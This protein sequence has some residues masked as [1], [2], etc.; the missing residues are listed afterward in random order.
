MKGI[1][2]LS[3][4]D[5]Y[6]KKWY[7]NREVRNN[8]CKILVCARSELKAEGYGKFPWVDILPNASILI[9]EDNKNLAGKK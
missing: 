6:F 9:E 3:G 4:L 2:A 5:N 7:P 8:K 1:C